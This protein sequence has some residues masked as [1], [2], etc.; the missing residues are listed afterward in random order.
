MAKRIR[1]KRTI[2]TLVD[3]NGHITFIKCTQCHWKAPVTSPHCSDEEIR[4]LFSF[5]DHNCDEHQVGAAFRREGR[6]G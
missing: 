3:D 4:E 6:D 5:W 1:P 2:E